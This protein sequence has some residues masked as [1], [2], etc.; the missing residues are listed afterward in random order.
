GKKLIDSALVQVRVRFVA[1][2]AGSGVSCGLASSGQ[3]LCWGSNEWGSVGDGELDEAL[4]PRL[5]VSPGSFSGVA[6]GAGTACGMIGSSLYCW[7]YN[8]VGQIGDGTTRSRS[9]PV[10]VGDSLQF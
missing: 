1:V 3:A 5:V 9:V 6:V 8:G 10:L 2:Y 4:T 7:G